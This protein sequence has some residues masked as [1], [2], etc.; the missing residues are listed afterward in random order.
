MVEYQ[1]SCNANTYVFVAHSLCIA[2]GARNNTFGIPG[3]EEYSHYLK[4]LSDARAIRQS[5]VRPISLGWDHRT[6][7]TIEH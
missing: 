1:Y 2:V 3:V 4:E 7:A 6:L 5:L